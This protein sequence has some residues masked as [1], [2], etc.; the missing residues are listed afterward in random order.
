L[1]KNAGDIL[2][3][4]EWNDE[5]ALPPGCRVYNSSGISVA[6]GSDVALTFDAEHFDTDTMHSTA[7]N[8]SRV[9]FTTA[10]RYHVGFNIQVQSPTTGT[11][12][13]IKI[14]GDG[15]TVIAWDRKVADAGNLP[16]HVDTVYEFTAGQYVEFIVNH[17]EGSNLTV[18]RTSDYS[19][20]AWAT[21]EGEH[22]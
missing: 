8:T 16:M 11:R 3:A 17:N 7:S 21:W 1:T 5:A 4:E 22:S 15:T 14:R 2:T 6:S 20:E 10:G 12:V 18:A 13:D 19:P 9:T